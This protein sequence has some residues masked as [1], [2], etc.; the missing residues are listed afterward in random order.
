MSVNVKIR[1]VPEMN[2]VFSSSI[3]STLRSSV[4]NKLSGANI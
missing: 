3:L 2:Q 1:E 4:L